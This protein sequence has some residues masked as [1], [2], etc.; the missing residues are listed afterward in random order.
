MSANEE[1]ALFDELEGLTAGQSKSAWNLDEILDV[2]ERLISSDRERLACMKEA[3][4]KAEAELKKHNEELA[5]AES[6]NSFM[7]K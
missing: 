2:I 3:L 1:H 5:L 7:E 6:N 4:E